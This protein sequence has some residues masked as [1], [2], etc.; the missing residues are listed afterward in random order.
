MSTPIKIYNAL[1]AQARESG[2]ATQ[3]EIELHV[4][5]GI[6]VRLAASNYRN[7]FVLKGG[8]LLAAFD[9][10]RPTRDV[11]VAALD[12]DNDP[13]HMA[14]VIR[15]ILSTPAD[16]GVIFDLD[17]ITAVAIRDEDE[18]AGVR[19]TV[20]A[21][22]HTA[23]ARPHID[24]NVGDPIEPGP[25]EIEVPR[26]LSTAAPIQ[27]RGYPIPMVIAEKL[28]TAVQRGTASTRWRDFGDIWMLAH[29][30]D[31]DGDA[32][33]TAMT[34]VASHRQ[35]T[36][37]PLNGILDGFPAGTDTK[38]SNWLR[39]TKHPVAKD[40]PTVIAWVIEFGDPVVMRQVARKKWDCSGLRWS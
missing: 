16:D 5:D 10:R 9:N 37:G 29:S 25:Q 6:L 24:I 32:L 4:L 30:H 1:R 34:A 23:E 11:D 19:V 28:V 2:R 14:R 18:Y 17:S 40:F 7:Q 21:K 26:T 27:V 15:E 39:K 3:A 20:S 12:L 22:L 13:E 31:L 35:A 33:L 8:V 36:L 38:W